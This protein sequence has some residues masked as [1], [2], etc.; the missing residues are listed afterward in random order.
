MTV[1]SGKAKRG[2]EQSLGCG[3]ICF[4]KEREGGAIWSNVLINCRKAESEIEKQGG[5]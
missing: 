3:G 1:E 4:D 2:G 5:Y